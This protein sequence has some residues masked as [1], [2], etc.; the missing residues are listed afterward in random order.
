MTSLHRAI[1]TWSNLVDVYIAL[2]EFG[3]KQFIE[4]GLPAEKIMV[5]GNFVYPAPAEPGQG[6]GGYALF[7]GRFNEVKGVRILLSAWQ[8]LNGRVPLKIVGAG[9]LASFVEDGA[10]GDPSIEVVPW[11]PRAEL[12]KVLGEAK[13][14]IF[15]STW[16][17][18][19]S[20]ALIEA[21]AMGTPVIA[22]LL[23]SMIEM[24]DPR[25]TGLLFRAGEP[26][27]LAAKVEWAWAHQAELS[28]MRSHARS[29][30]DKKYT[31]QRNFE[32]LMGVYEIAIQKA[33]RPSVRA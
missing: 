25:R 20:L 7:L 6:S 24:I 10:R 21:F 17:E 13:V 2:T 12:L 11:L 8:R 16:Y 1:G 30:Y 4:G 28:S 5:K 15:P 33:R 26:D 32:E 31:P 29:E 23:G 27:D 3:R 9:P 19:Q 14:L 22:S 18:G